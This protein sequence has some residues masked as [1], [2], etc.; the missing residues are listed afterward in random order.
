MEMAVQVTTAVI[1]KV[2][3]EMTMELG[4]GQIRP[5]SQRWKWQ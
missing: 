4:E 3:L 2:T 5:W 1:L